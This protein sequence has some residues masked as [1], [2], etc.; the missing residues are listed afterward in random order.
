MAGGDPWNKSYAPGSFVS[1]LTRA[2]AHKVNR[3]GMRK[4]VGGNDFMDAEE[5]PEPQRIGCPGQRPLSHSINYLTTPKG[6][7]YNGKWISTDTSSPA[8]R[9]SKEANKSARFTF[10]VDGGNICSSEDELTELQHIP[11]SASIS[12]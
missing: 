7:C 11:T 12:T 4:E 3:A 9:V 8:K 6:C 2:Q 1:T 5:H 10:Y